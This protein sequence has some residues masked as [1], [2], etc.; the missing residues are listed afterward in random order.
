MRVIELS[1]TVTASNDRDAETLRARLNT[2]GRLLVNLMSSPGAGKTTLLRRIVQDLDG[3]LKI[4][5]MEAD[6]ASE[7]DALR[8]EEAGAVSIQAFATPS[9]RPEADSPSRS[10]T[11]N[12]IF[13]VII[14]TESTKFR[15]VS[16]GL[17]SKLI[18]FLLCAA[19]AACQWA[20]SS[21]YTV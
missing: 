7:V 1:S 16:R 5:V 12:I 17:K 4:G 10:T 11:K 21:P 20:Y 2:E 19:F 15:G 14:T 13:A 9:T 8:M 18:Y 3:R 6:I